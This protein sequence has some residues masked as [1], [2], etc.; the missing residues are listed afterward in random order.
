MIVRQV[1][2]GIVDAKQQPTVRGDIQD[3]LVIDPLNFE[4]FHLGCLVPNIVGVWQQA[5]LQLS[6]WPAAMILE[7][8]SGRLADP[9]LGLISQRD[10]SLC[11]H[12]NFRAAGDSDAAGL[13]APVGLDLQLQV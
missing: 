9:G 3:S 2:N 5:Y 4:W 11:C 10:F 6:Q 1:T 7:R 12:A 13:P 8:D